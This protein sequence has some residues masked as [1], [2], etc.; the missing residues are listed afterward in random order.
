MARARAEFAATI[1]LAEK[2]PAGDERRDMYLE[3]A[4]EATIALGLRAP[5]SGAALSLAPWTGAD[6]PGSIPNTLKY[7]LLVAGTAGKHVAL[8]A[9][10]VPKGWVASFCSDRVCA[11]FKTNVAIPSSGVKVIEF[12]LVPPGQRGDPGKVRVVASEGGHVVTATT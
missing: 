5:Q 11:P 8:H 9:A 10:D 6:L 12:Q 1:A 7:R 2:L 4:Q 3:E